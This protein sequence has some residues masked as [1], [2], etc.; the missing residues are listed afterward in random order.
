MTAA[1]LPQRRHFHAATRSGSA[2]SMTCIS[3]PYF[4]HI[5]NA[6]FLSRSNLAIVSPIFA[7]PLYH[8]FDLKSSTKSRIFC[9]IYPLPRTR[10]SRELGYMEYP[11]VISGFVTGW[12]LNDSSE[13]IGFSLGDNT[14]LTRPHTRKGPTRPQGITQTTNTPIPLQLTHAIFWIIPLTNRGP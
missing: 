7:Y 12:G 6:F 14:T 9:S 2:I 8:R 3:C 1:V 5:F 4:R 11:G 10:L 13:F